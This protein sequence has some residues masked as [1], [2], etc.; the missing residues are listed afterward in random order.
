MTAP[1]SACLSFHFSLFSPVCVCVCVLRVCVLPV[2]VCVNVTLSI[3]QLY[4]VAT[5]IEKRISKT[6][7]INPPFSRDPIQTARN[8][9]R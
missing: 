6:F 4:D 9:S 2:C 3:Q 5:L 7:V 8:N 1:S